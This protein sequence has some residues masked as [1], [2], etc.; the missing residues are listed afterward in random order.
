MNPEFEQRKREI[1]KAI[2]EDYIS[3]GEPV[4]SQHVARRS[5]VDVSPATIRAVMADLEELGY[6]EKPH[7][8]AGRIPTDRGFRFFVDSLIQVRAPA[9]RDREA[10]DRTVP[11]NATVTEAIDQASAIL[12]DLSQHASLVVIPKKDEAPLRHIEL[13]RLRDDRALAVLVS[14]AG[15]VHNKLLQ[16]DAPLS[17]DELTQAAN[18]LNDLLRDLPLEAARERIARELADQAALYNQLTRRALVLA[19]GL[20]ADSPADP[21]SRLLVQGHGSLLEDLSVDV[22]QARAA[23]RLLEEKKRILVVLDQVRAAGQMQIFIGSESG[24][25]HEGVSVVATPYGEGEVVG[26]LGVIGP[27]RMNYSKVIGLVDY[28]AKALNKALPR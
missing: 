14:P 26:T 3:K 23:L 22:E 20:M 13:V 11:V 21:Q 16:L 5:E 8:S 7:T 28:T 4:G 2:V 1:L 25:S 9:S 27:T 24:F 6:L 12:H 19:Q 10:I 18:Y 15:I 17:Q